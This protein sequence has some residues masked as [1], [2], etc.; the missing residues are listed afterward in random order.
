[1]DPQQ[2]N[3][4]HNFLFLFVKLKSTA[5]RQ[6]LLDAPV[7]LQI[8]F[9]VLKGKI[10]KIHYSYRQVVRALLDHQKVNLHADSSFKTHSF[11]FKRRTFKLI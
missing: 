1:M 7:R 4:N 10:L 11:F 6:C 5:P 2:K 3:S 9:F 8:I